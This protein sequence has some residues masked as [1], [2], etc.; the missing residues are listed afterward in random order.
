MI[1]VNSIILL[2]GI[3]F[4]SK[5]SFSQ[6]SRDFYES[7]VYQIQLQDYNAAI[8]EFNKAIELDSANVNAYLLR[9][10]SKDELKDYKGAID[11]YSKAIKYNTKF[12]DAFYNRGCTY[13][14]MGDTTNA[15]LDW[16][17]AMNLGAKSVKKLISK[18]CENK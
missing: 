10:D 16:N 2:I 18:Y 12:K 8:K 3:L 11:D 17:S 6:T 4:L 9:G 15:C 14:K 13:Y 1:K 5:V 7:G